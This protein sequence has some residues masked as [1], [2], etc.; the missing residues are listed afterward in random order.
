[1]RVLDE[2]GI[3]LLF[4]HDNDPRFASWMGI[5]RGLHREPEFSVLGMVPVERKMGVV[6]AALQ[7]GVALHHLSARRVALI[8]C[9][10]IAPAWQAL[11]SRGAGQTIDQ[12]LCDGITVVARREPTPKFDFAWCEEAIAARRQAGH[13]VICDLTGLADTGAMGR[14]HSQLMGIVSVVQSG[15]TFE[16]RLTEIHRQIPPHLNRGVLFIDT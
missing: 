4:P 8:D 6:S 9:N 2:L 13:F 7:L 14:L 1:M 12:E 11:S 5:A 3:R 10:T 15:A 16:W